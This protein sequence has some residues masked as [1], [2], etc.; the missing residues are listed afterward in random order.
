MTGVAKGTAT[1]T[2][3]YGGFNATGTANVDDAVL[4]SLTLSHTNPSLAKGLTLNLTVTGNYSNGTSTAIPVSDA[5]SLYVS[6][7]CRLVVNL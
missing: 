6:R 5:V 2:A 7:R 3:S 1:I 4:Q